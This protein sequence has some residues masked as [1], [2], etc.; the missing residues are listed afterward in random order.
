[1]NSRESRSEAMISRIDECLDEYEQWLSRGRIRLDLRA[2]APVD[3]AAARAP[4]R[5]KAAAGKGTRTRK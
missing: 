4:R 3:P 5:P 2:Q 1:M